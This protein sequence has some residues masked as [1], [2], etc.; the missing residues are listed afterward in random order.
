MAIS[1][2][3]LDSKHPFTTAM[4]LPPIHIRCYRCNT[5]LP[6][7]N[8]A[9][10]EE[11]PK[12]CFQSLVIMHSQDLPP[13]PFMLL[14]FAYLPTAMEK[15]P[16]RTC[17]KRLQRTQ[18]SKRIEKKGL[19]VYPADFLYSQKALSKTS[20]TVRW[21]IH[22]CVQGRVR[23]NELKSTYHQ[24]QQA[25][26]A[27]FIHE[28]YQAEWFFQRFLFRIFRNISYFTGLGNALGPRHS[29]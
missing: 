10:E 28:N 16:V 25:L 27:A 2:F 7:Q 23:F 20:A 24:R 1:V 8:I 9:L 22:S 18:D 14:T 21:T 13:L 26:R 29:S 11:D 6:I 15:V 19:V 5:C 3:I 12:D 4:N 17:T